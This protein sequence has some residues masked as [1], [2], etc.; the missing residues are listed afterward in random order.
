MN[1]LEIFPDES[2]EE[3]KWWSQTKKKI[4]EDS[5]EEECQDAGY[6][7]HQMNTQKCRPSAESKVAG[8]VTLC[9]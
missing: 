6:K 7:S 8:S 3:R 5:D 1:A 4:V 2:E 9:G